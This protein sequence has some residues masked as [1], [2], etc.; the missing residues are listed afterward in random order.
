[1]VR[2]KAAIQKWAMMG[3]PLAHSVGNLKPIG[4]KMGKGKAP[5]I[6]INELDQIRS[7]SVSKA[8]RGGRFQPGTKALREISRFQKS[9]ELLIPKPPFLRLV[10]EI[11][12]R[13]HGCH[14][15]QAGAVL[16]LHVATEAYL[17]WLLEDTNLCTIH[18]KHVTIKILPKDMRLT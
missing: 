13:D 18:V 9:K 17:I 6:G 14:H 4:K 10:H 3:V 7:K 12:Q 16:A 2:T 11:L 5:Q 1:M 15:I 8:A